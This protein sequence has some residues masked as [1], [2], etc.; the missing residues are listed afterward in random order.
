MGEVDLDMEDRH[1]LELSPDQATSSGLLPLVSTCFVGDLDDAADSLGAHAVRSDGGYVCLCNVHVL[2]EAMHDPALRRAVEAAVFRF[3]DG[4]PVA[5]LLRRLGFEDARRV[6]GPDLFPRVVDTGR[7]IGLRHFFV[8][9]TESTLTM[10]RRAIADRFPE[11]E[12]VGAVAL[13]FADAPAV[14]ESLVESVRNARA[15]IV[16]VAL[17]APKQELWM[18][19]AAPKMTGATFVGVG[20]AFDFLAGT[21]PR[22]PVAFQRVGLEWLHRLA[23]E[24]RRLA[25][26]YIRC[27]TEFVA[28]A[29]VELAVRRLGSRA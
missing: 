5:W 14:D 27:N 20:A 4:E 3:P 29:G 22:A 7:R 9:S 19:R 6:G 18:A 24:P 17:G 26:R 28:R 2:S 10:L 8:G 21:K 23:S 15:H 12:V 16:W 25:S 13:P 11:A 1:S